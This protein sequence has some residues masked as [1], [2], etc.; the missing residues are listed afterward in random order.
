MT[1]YS[2]CPTYFCLKHDWPNYS[3]NDK[4]KAEKIASKALDFIKLV[5]TL[6]SKE[7]D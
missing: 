1:I 7:K 4:E 3:G 5:H 2:A 6:D